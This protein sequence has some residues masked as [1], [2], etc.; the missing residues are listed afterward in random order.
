M[1]MASR[2][3]GRR[4]GILMLASQPKSRMPKQIRPSQAASY[5]RNDGVSAMYDT[6][7]PASVPSM[8]ARG[9]TLRSQSPTKAPMATTM[10]WMKVHA[11]ATPH[12]SRASPVLAISGIMMAK[13]TMK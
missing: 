8:A 7:M 11:I 1:M 10:P 3:A 2:P 9:V 6:A 4:S 12:A 13:V 5:T